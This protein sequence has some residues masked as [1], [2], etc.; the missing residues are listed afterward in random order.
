ML[1]PQKSLR[2]RELKE[3]QLVTTV[4][5]TQRYMQEYGKQILIGV[6]G[7][8][9][10]IAL[11][12]MV[13][14]SKQRSNTIAYTTLT[15]AEVLYLGGQLDAA[16]QIVENMV[17]TYSGTD[18]AGIGYHTLGNLALDTHQYDVAIENYQIYLDDYDDD[19]VLSASS[20][21]G[22]AACFEQQKK[23]TEAA[24]LY[25]A[26]V[27]ANPTIFL[28]PQYLLNA[29]RC[30]ETAKDIESARTACQQVL[31]QYPD[32]FYSQLAEMTLARL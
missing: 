6:A 5:K 21:A 18:A 22:I 2:K 16:R 13:V 17:K 10:V 27:T 3:D 11:I 4:I 24:D 20:Q 32:S 19:P 14:L 26:A 25:Q 15:Q 7:V 31:D 12:S 9:A 29:S 8:V 23:F 1:K 30:F 28:A